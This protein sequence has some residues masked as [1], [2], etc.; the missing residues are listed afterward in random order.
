MAEKSFEQLTLSEKVII[1]RSGFECIYG[2]LVWS[3]SPIDAAA[4]NYPTP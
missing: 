4:V 3:D 1:A 2:T